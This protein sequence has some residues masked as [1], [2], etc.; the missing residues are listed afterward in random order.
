ML[1]TIR[2]RLRGSVAE[3]T[4]RG[5]VSREAQREATSDQTRL[6]NLHPVLSSGLCPACCLFRTPVP[7]IRFWANGSVGKKRGRHDLY[8]ALVANTSKDTFAGYKL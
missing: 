2:D 5:A 4:K 6:A 7:I 8:H 3:A 1:A